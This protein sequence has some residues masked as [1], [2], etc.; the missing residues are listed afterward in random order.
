MKYLLLLGFLCGCLGLQAQNNTKNT[1][2]KEESV[3]D[4]DKPANVFTLAIGITNKG[5]LKYEHAFSDLL[6]LSITGSG[7]YGW[8]PGF[9]AAVGPRFYLSSEGA[10]EGFFVSPR[11][12]VGYFRFD[13]WNSWGRNNYW[14]SDNFVTAGGGFQ[15][16]YQFLLGK[17]KNIVIDLA[18]GFKYLPIPRNLKVRYNSNNS[19][20]GSFDDEDYQG[21]RAIWLLTGPGSLW[22]ATIGFGFAF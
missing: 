2:S 18:G 4:A 16:G 1:A 13:T 6:S 7:Y 15:M 3:S 22:D 11:V 9:L 21:V 20:S 12:H 8:F 17:K 14:S 10:P 5:R 19:S